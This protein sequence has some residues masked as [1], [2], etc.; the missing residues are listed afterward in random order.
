MG[1]RG[2]RDGRGAAVGRRP[3][4]GGGG[5]RVALDTG[6][7]VPLLAWWHDAPAGAARG[8][9]VL[10]PG[11][12]VPARV[13]RGWAR[14]LSTAGWDVLRIEFPGVGDSPLAPVDVPG[15]MDL[16]ATRDLD[17]AIRAA[18]AR[19]GD[20]PVVLV[21][22]S[23][24]AWLALLA[25]G[26]ARI[27]ALL[28]I[29]SMSGEIRHLRPRARPTLW[30]GVAL[31]VPVVTR[32]TG[33]LPA[34]AGLGTDAP[35]DALRQWARWCRRRGFVLT[36]PDVELHADDLTAPVRVLLP[37]DDEWATRRAV[38]QLWGPATGGRHE[39][40]E[41]DAVAR[42]VR[43]GHLGLLR[44]GV[45]DDVRADAIAWLADVTATA[46]RDGGRVRGG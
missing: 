16:W 28:G 20:R 23:A 34:W 7:D 13:L 39:V 30:L 32:L 26:A 10:A 42:G 15:G 46:H 37:R 27:D 12:A 19:A 3:D 41:V 22:H 2:D 36:A 40:V 6:T 14:S 17:T 29:A 38:D 33:R 24:G 18:G 9:A 43:I 31:V 8:V 45:A 21:G 35:G 25:R 4:G 44:D 5:R 1:S 11:V